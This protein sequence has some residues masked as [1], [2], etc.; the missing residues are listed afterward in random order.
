MA[1]AEQGR[2]TEAVQAQNLAIQAAG[3]QGLTG[4][5]EHLDANRRRYEQE[6]PCRTPWEAVIFEK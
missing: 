4:W 1:Y 3:N 2:F 5:L 6:Q